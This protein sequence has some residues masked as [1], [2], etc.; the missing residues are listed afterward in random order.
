MNAV[1]PRRMKQV[2]ITH[3]L[4]LLLALAGGAAAAFSSVAFLVNDRIMFRERQVAELTGIAQILA[5]QSTAVVAF[6]QRQSAEEL[7]ASLRDRHDVLSAHLFTSD[8]KWLAGY[9][10]SEDTTKQPVAS[11]ERGSLVANDGR[12][13]VTVP[14]VEAGHELGTLE[15]RAVV[16]PLVGYLPRYLGMLTG[17]TLASL[18][19]ILALSAHLQRV[20]AEPLDHL[21]AALRQFN[22]SGNSACGITLPATAELGELTRELNTLLARV[23]SDRSQLEEQRERP[24]PTAPYRSSTMRSS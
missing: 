22:L 15:V 1:I 12:L 9:S 17:I 19:V 6:E 24:Q 3:K 14:V 20:I 21:V 7:L 16:A 13:V 10:S 8:Q 2:A 23:E 18:F 5:T 11:A 4:T